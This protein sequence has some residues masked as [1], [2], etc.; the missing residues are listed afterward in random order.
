VSLLLVDA[1]GTVLVRT[2]LDSLA[3]P[4]NFVAKTAKVR[5]PAFPHAAAVVLDPNNQLKTNNRALP[6]GAR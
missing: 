2:K 4:T 5:L 6:P 3:A 1:G